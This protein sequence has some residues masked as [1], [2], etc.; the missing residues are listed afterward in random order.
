LASPIGSKPKILLSIDGGGVRGI[1][2]LRFVA[3]IEA[4]IGKKASEIFTHFTGASIGLFNC[5]AL[6]YPGENGGAKWSAKEIFPLFRDSM[7][8]IFHESWKRRIETLNGM[9]RPYYSPDGLEQVAKE[10]LGDTSFNKTI[11][12]LAA[13]AVNVAD[14][15][16]YTFDSR[17]CHDSLKMKE[18]VRACTAAETYFPSY[19]LEIDDKKMTFADG[20]TYANNPS[21]VG[22]TRLLRAAE[23]TDRIFVLSLGTGTIDTSLNPHEAKHYGELG[24]GEHI[25]PLLFNTATSNTEQ[26]MRNLL[27]GDFK[28]GNNH[29]YARLQPIIDKEHSALDDASIANFDYLMQVAEDYIKTHDQEITDIC[30]TLMHCNKDS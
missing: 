26:M 2:P 13:P 3:E 25:I 20:G 8:T 6:T 23:K 15:G 17:D 10:Y 22:Y 4:R 27:P 29:S 11:R 7:G 24:W 14:Q 1:I 21:M 16:A 19:S 9:T 28:S 18:V 30:E 12:P 5:I